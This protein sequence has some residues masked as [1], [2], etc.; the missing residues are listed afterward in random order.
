MP[1][2][3]RRQPL[4]HKDKNIS[5]NKREK[6]QA[7]D[8]EILLGEFRAVALLKVGICS[9]TAARDVRQEQQPPVEEEAPLAPPVEGV[10]LQ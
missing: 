4:S 7:L 3:T 10:A 1:A 8:L 2:L 5:A 9:V 6:F